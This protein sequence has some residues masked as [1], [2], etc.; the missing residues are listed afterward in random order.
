MSNHQSSPAITNCILWN[1]STDEIFN[2]NSS[3]PIVTYCDIAGEL[4]PGTG[5]INASPEF[6]DAA[7]GDI[8]LSSISP[9]IDTGSNASVPEWLATDFE[10]DARIIDGDGDDNAIVDMGVDEVPFI[11]SPT[12]TATV[13]PTPSATPTV[14]PTISPTV[15]PTISPTVAPTP[16]PTPNQYGDASDDGFVDSFDLVILQNMILEKSP[17]YAGADASADG[18]VDSFDLVIV[19]NIILEKTAAE[20]MHIGG[21]DFSS[22]AGSD[23]WAKR[24][25]IFTPPPALNT[26][27]DTDPTGWVEATSAQYTNISAQDGDVCTLAGLSGN[28]TTLQCKFTIAEGAYAGNITSIGVTFNGTSEMSGDLLQLWAWNFNTSAWQQLGTDISLGNTSNQAYIRW[29]AW[30]KVFADYIDASNYM[31]ILYNH[32]TVSKYLNV[33]YVKLEIV[34]PE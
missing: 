22:G 24:N 27:F 6:V 33:D 19:Q 14:S 16:T 32:N 2:A 3:T 23:R 11:V 29:T 10:G 17:V 8:H 26:T 31:Y 1:D 18:Y 34:S 9:C 28:Y 12:P 25:N 13:S 20:N 5:N 30:G 7:N 21:Y 4:Y 15:S